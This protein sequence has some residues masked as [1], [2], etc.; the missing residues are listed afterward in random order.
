MSSFQGLLQ[1][2][3]FVRLRRYG[4]ELTPE[5]RILS[6]RPVLDDGTGGRIVGWRDGDPAVSKLSSWKGERSEPSVVV[7]L[8]TPVAMPQPAAPP[9]QPTPALPARAQPAAP[10]PAP[11]RPSAAVMPVDVAAE[12]T[13]D[14]DDWEWTIALARARTAVEEVE[15][16]PSPPPP[17]AAAPPA[18]REW[19]DDSRV[20]TRP[21]IAIPRMTTPSTVIPVPALPA[22]VTGC[23][24]MEPV[25]RAAPGAPAAASRFAKGTGPVD[26]PTP[27][28]PAMLVEDTIP[29]LS[30]GDRTRPGIAMPP[31]PSRSAEAARSSVGDRTKPGIALP[32]A[33]RAVELP[34][35]KRRMSPR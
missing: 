7:E 15:A 11:V 32:P 31:P 26:P 14:E 34:S 1:R 12:P 18:S 8:A 6:T 29:N 28:S 9:A 21:A 22:M 25:V 13:V 30:V 27:R 23:S 4:L 2:W 24:R 3:G 16:D 33:A 10:A 20:S 5:G 17:A 19:R 35:I